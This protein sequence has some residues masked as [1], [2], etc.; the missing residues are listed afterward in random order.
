MSNRIK[1][2]WAFTLNDLL[3]VHHL[4][5]NDEFLAACDATEV[6]VDRRGNATNRY[7][8]GTKGVTL[9]DKERAESE[10]TLVKIGTME[11][12]DQWHDVWAGEDG[13]FLGFATKH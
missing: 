1:E 7:R 8:D 3:D 9:I 13:R 12:A 11:Y 10:D 4:N 2:R 5:G 6:V